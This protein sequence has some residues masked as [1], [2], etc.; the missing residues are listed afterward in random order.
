MK[1][2]LGDWV[3]NLEVVGIV[4]LILIVFIGIP[5]LLTIANIWNLF[6][7]KPKG[8]AGAILLATLLIGALFYGLFLD[9]SFEPV[10]DY[11]EAVYDICKHYT[12]NSAHRLSFWLPSLVGV[13][14]LLVLGVFPAKHLSPIFAASAV[15]AVLLGNVM[16]VLYAI[17]VWNLEDVSSSLILY[18]YHFNLLLLSIQHIRRHIQAQTVLIKERKTQFRYD[19][20]KKLYTFLAKTSHFTLFSFALLFPLAALLEI[21]LIL[22]GQG[23]DGVIKAFTMT[24]DWT[25]STQTP[26]PPMQYD[27]HYLCT[28]AAGGHR[29]VVHPQRFGTRL[30]QPILVNRQLCIANAFEELIQEKAPRFHHHVRHFYDTHG[31][32]LSKKI[33]TPFRADLVYVL[34]KPLEWVFLAFL[35]LLD[36]HPEQRIA[37]QYS[38]KEEQ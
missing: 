24:A 2:A 1:G 26:P 32:P 13:A 37:T 5:L 15:S 23:P 31:Y 27:G 14:G 30:G 19:W 35:Y 8:N 12:I 34:M 3:E 28:V 38:W 20:V 6:S 9:I 33:T 22:L 36:R 11:Y 29:K 18:A 21:V 25:F 17:Q 7:K 16:N 4:L 10:G